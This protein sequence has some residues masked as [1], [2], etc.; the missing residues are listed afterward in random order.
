MK[1]Q[2]PAGWIAALANVLDGNPRPNAELVALAVAAIRALPLS[3]AKAGELPASACFS[4]AA[5]A[6][7]PDE[8][9]LERTGRRARRLVQTR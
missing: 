9:R 8:L 3:R 4:I 1:K 2:V 7:N 5:D 6:K